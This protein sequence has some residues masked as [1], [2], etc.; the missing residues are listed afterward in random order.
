MQ[1]A[2]LKDDNLISYKTRKEILEDLGQKE[3]L[4]IFDGYKPTYKPIEQKKSPLDQQISLGI[5]TEERKKISE[6]IKKM[7]LGGEKTTVSSLVRSR[8]VSD[9]DLAEWRERAEKGLKELNS[10]K[11]NREEISKKLRAC[12]VQYDSMED[13]DSETAIVLNLKIKELEA[14]KKELARPTARRSA[15][16]SGRVTFNEANIIRWRAGRLTLTVADYMRFLVFGH[17]PFTESDRHLSIDARRRFYVA[18]IDISK[19]GWG[20]PPEI[21]ECPNCSRYAYENKELRAKLERLQKMSK[22]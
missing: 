13:D 18:I 20:K 11:W 22:K 19:N 17:L 21:E 14:M 4:E 7:K 12:Y 3:L 8:A 15:R 10:L 9:V 1:K 5:S 6:D 2:N 16:M